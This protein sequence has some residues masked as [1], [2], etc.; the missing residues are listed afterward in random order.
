VDILA[1][2]V[3]L[4]GADRIMMGTDYCFDIAYTEPVR[5]VEQ[6][7]GLSDEQRALILGG[8]ANRLLRLE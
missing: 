5:V 1:D 6:T 4:V 2:L 7:P 3:R 8:N